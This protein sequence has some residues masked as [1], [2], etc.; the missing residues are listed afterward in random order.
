VGGGTATGL[1]TL[2]DTITALRDHFNHHDGKRR[3][4]AL[5]SPT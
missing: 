3:F 4:V 2:D 1:T 5:L